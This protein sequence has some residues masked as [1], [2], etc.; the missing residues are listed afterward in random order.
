M[1]SDVVFGSPLPSIVLTDGVVTLRSFEQRDVALV[2]EAAGDDL[3][4]KISTVPKHYTID[5]GRAY[6]ERQHQR[7]M[8]GAG[9]SLA[10]SDVGTDTAMG[11]VGLWISQLSKGRAEIGYWVVPSA[12]GHGVA[13]L[14][15]TLLAEWAFAN[16]DVDRLSL[17]IEPSNDASISTAERAGFTREGVLRGW[18]RIDGA[19]RDVVSFACLRPAGSG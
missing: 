2:E 19:P 4:T 10:I 5:A 15:L 13:T 8:S 18:E 1:A 17:F 6:I 11:Q 3:I 14:A 9:W 16:S 12:R 7:L